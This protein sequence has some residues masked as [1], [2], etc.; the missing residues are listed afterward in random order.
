MLLLLGRLFRVLLRVTSSRIVWFQRRQVVHNTNRNNVGRR[1]VLGTLP[2]PTITIFRNVFRLLRVFV[3]P[4]GN[5][6]PHGFL[7]R[8]RPHLRGL[9][10]LKFLRTIT[11]HSN[12]TI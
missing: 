4:F 12:G 3:H 8:D 1:I 6:R 2:C 9:E 5:N 7:F 11:R 10:R